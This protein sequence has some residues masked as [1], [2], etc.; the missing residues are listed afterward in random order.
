MPERSASVEPITADVRKGREMTDQIETMTDELELTQAELDEIVGGLTKV[1]AGTLT[2]ANAN[3][4]TGA[5]MVNA[6]I[7][8]I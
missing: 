5:T 4:Y 8:A 1:G 2:L 7:I 6:G 3:T